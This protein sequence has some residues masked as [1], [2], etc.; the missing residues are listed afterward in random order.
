MQDL[1]IYKDSII[2]LGSSIKNEIALELK[3]ILNMKLIN[4]DRDK[5]SFFD[6]FT[7]YDFDTYQSLKEKNEQ[8]SLL[9]IKKYDM[10]YLKY[11][12]DNIKENVI[13]NFSINEEIDDEILLNNIKLFNN[14]IYLK[15]NNN[16]KNSFGNK[17][18]DIRN[19]SKEDIMDEIINIVKFKDIL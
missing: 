11:V 14:I 1:N 10:Q 19:L 12:F 3:N 6:D 16:L 4:L 2:L 5:H 15:D 8:K 9:Y 17:I 18:I 13:I 7:D